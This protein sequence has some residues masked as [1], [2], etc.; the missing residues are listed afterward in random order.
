MAEIDEIENRISLLDEYIDF[1]E[2]IDI[3]IDETPNDENDADIDD[4]DMLEYRKKQA[5]SLLYRFKEIYELNILSPENGYSILNIAEDEN[6]NIKKYLHRFLAYKSKTGGK[7]AN[8]D[9]SAELFEYISANAVKSFFGKGTNV[10]MV[11]EGRSSLTVEVL[12][13]ITQK[14]KEYSGVYH[15]LPNRAKDDG[16][17][18][19]VY[20]PIDKRDVGNIIVLGQACVGKHYN[21]KNPIYERWENEYITYAV[22]PP[23]TLLSLVYYLDADE[24]RK[25]HSKFR[26]SLVFDRARI[27]K[28][29]DSSDTALNE[30]IVDFVDNNINGE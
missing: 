4:I 27:I 21:Q 8:S 7:G 12:K 9:G 5:L 11:G 10:I 3:Y 17:D 1:E 30:R 24:L 20:K 26:N 15:N 22:K 14:L 29:F 2:I 23:T 16:V 6:L 25:V 28:Y 18:F 19:I 13:N